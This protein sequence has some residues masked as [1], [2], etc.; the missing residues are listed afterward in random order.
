GPDTNF[1]PDPSIFGGPQINSFRLPAT[2]D[3]RIEVRARAAEDITGFVCGEADFSLSW[4]GRKIVPKHMIA[5][6]ETFEGVLT[7]SFGTVLG[8]E[9]HADDV[10]AITMNSDD[11]LD[12]YLELL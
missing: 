8:F 6:D 9:G 2:G 11:D 12:A 3:Y 1:T 5:Y 7:E 4:T 10:I